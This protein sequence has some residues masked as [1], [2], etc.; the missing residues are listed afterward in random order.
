[1]FPAESIEADFDV[2]LQMS[3]Y[4]LTRN[5]LSAIELANSGT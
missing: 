5:G 1:M 3:P 4:G 2:A